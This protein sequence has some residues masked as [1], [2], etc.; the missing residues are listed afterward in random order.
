M[1]R[2]DE[3][4]VISEIC[5]FKDCSPFYKKEKKMTINIF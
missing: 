1:L 5:Y 2:I 3:F 4:R